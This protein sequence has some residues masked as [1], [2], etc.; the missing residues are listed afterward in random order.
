MAKRK[1]SASRATKICLSLVF[2]CALL[3]SALHGA[4]ANWPGFRGPE[5][6]GVADGAGIPERWSATENV[7]WKTEIPGRG[8]SSPV[9]WEDRVFLTT[10]VDSGTPRAAKKGLYF[11]GEQSRPPSTVHQW[12]VMCLSA[13]TGKVLWQRTVREGKPATPIHIKNSYASETPVTD[14]ERL[15]ASFGNV[16]VFCLDFEGNV[17]W[18]KDVEPRKTQMNWGPAASPALHGN[19]LFLVNDNQEQSYLTALD[20]RTGEEVWR[21]DREEKSNWA[22][23]YVWKNELR[24]ELVT[25]GTHR[26]RSYDLEGRLL[27]EVATGSAITIATPYAYKDLLIVSSGYVMAPRKPLF[28]IRAGGAGDLSAAGGAPSALAWKLLNAAPYNPT[29]LAY[30]DRLYVLYDRGLFA[31]FDAATGNV[32]YDKQRLELADFTASPWASDGKIYCLNESG[33]TLVIE[34]GDQFKPLHINALAEDDMCMA[35]PAIAGQR[36]L[37]R[38]SERLYCLMAPVP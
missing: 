18:S 15:Y 1:M 3:K 7:A 10:A 2:A 37:I 17:V 12:Q 38:S 13:T 35:T 34:A 21:V 6:T 22:T 33:E 23:P 32:I 26:M 9:V 24:T 14:G 16:G 11:G 4:D 20:K 31:C 27:W 29:T 36:L 5:A 25:A 30:R 28:A 19:L 8:W